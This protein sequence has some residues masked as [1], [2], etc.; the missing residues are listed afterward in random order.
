MCIC[1]QLLELQKKIRS[2][3]SEEYWLTEKCSCPC[4]GNQLYDW[5][6]M[7]LPYPATSFILGDVNFAN[8]EDCERKRRYNKV[9]LDLLGSCVFQIY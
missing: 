1:V 7:R 3:L 2:E 5:T 4:P 8:E 9:S 6:M